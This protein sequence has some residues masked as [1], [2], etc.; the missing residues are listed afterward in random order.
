MLTVPVK[1]V[2]PVVVV[3]V[4][5]VPADVV[6]LVLVTVEVSVLTSVFC[7]RICSLE[8]MTGAPCPKFVV[9]MLTLP[10]TPTSTAGPVGASDW[11]LP[12][13]EM[14]F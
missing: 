4:V 10:P 11:R 8:I 3:P 1:T 9:S 6:V 12:E 5:P 7:C 14:L 2:V 13:R